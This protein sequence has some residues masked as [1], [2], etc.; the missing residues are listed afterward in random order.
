MEGGK[1]I[2]MITLPPRSLHGLC[3]YRKTGRHG[4]PGSFHGSSD[5]RRL[6]E[7]SGHRGPV[8]WTCAASNVGVSDLAWLYLLSILKLV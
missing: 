3:T 1:R 5:I 8:G 2:G 6:A 7:A 4:G